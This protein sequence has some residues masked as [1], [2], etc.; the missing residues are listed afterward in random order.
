MQER[1]IVMNFGTF[2]ALHPGHLSFLQQSRDLGTELVTVVA[3]DTT[4]HTVKK[5]QAWQTQ[6]ERIEALEGLGLADHRV[7]LWH[8]SDYMYWIKEIRPDVIAIGYDQDSFVALIDDVLQEHGIISTVV[9]LQPYK[10]HIYKTSLM[11]GVV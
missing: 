5:K 7:V 11:R 9:T 2:D 8:R 3:R 6:Q 1:R 10:A 4:V